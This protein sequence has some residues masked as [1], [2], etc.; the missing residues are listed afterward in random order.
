MSTVKPTGS[1]PPEI[2][3]QLEIAYATHVTNHTPEELVT[4]INYQNFHPNLVSFVWICICAKCKE[5][6]T[7]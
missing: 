2:L 6:E 5:K 7:K 1:L 4:R 3:R